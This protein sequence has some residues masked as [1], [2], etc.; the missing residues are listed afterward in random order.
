MDSCLSKVSNY[1]RKTDEQ[2]MKIQEN[3]QEMKD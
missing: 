1:F 3:M 2:M